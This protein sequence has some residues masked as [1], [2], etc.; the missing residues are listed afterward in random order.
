MLPENALTYVRPEV[1]VQDHAGQALS[2]TV[3]PRERSSKVRADTGVP[4]LLLALQFPKGQQTAPKF[5][6]ICVGKGNLEKLIKL[7]C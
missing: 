5:T 7:K 2:T 1:W 3:A 6:C 4:L